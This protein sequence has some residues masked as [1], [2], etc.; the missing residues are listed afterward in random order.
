MSK[1]IKMPCGDSNIV[2]EVETPEDII[3]TSKT[4]QRIIDSVPQAF[5]TVENVLTAGC[6]V[7]TGALKKLAEQEE[8]LEK[9]T[10]DFGLQ[11]T[12]EGNVFLVKSAAQ[13]SI[14]VSLVMKMR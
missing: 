9:A 5:E 13:A 10:F 14:K 11:F 6:T 2:I 7:L 12:A 8:S 3:E 4:G 1:L